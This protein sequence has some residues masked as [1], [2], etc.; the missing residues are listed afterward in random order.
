M[1]KNP[2]N[3]FNEKILSESK[4]RCCVKL[5]DDGCIDKFGISLRSDADHPNDIIDKDFTW[6]EIEE[7]YP[8]FYNEY[9]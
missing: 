2:I 6:E 3:N 8:E 5:F 9:L 1:V 4:C 7:L